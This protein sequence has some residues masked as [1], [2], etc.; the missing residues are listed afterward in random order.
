[1]RRTV[2]LLCLMLGAVAPLAALD[3]YPKTTLAEDG[4]ATWCGYCPDAYAGLDVV[5]SHYNYGEFLS[6]RYYATSGGLGTPET[7]AA[8]AYYGINAFPTVIFNGQ[9][10]VVGGSAFIAT[11]A[12][13][14]PIVQAAYF[15]PAPIRIEISDFSP[16]SGDISATVTMYS[17]T[18]VLAGDQIR[19]L[20][21]E[22]NVVYQSETYSYVTRDI[23]NDT[24]TLSGAGNT[25]VFNKS[26]DV[27]PG[28]NQANLHAVV[29][30]Q[31]AADKEVLQ[32]VSTFPEPSYSVRA[33]VPF[34]RV[35]VG[36]SA[37]GPPSPP[38]TIM[39]VGLA[40][41]FNIELI[42]DF[43]PPGW[44]ASY[45]DDQ[46]GHHTGPWTFALG[47]EESTEFS[48]DV[49]PSS[50]G[51]MKFHLEVS[52]PN[53]TTPLVIPFTYITDDADVLIVDDDGAQTYEN[54][55][56][57]ALD[58]LGISY[59]VWDLSA[60]KLS[61]DVLQAY[62][63]LIWQVGESYPTID[64]VDRAFLTQHLD[65]GGKLFVT[66]QDIGWELNYSSSGNYDPAWY[67]NY[68]HANWVTD[69]TNNYNLDGVAGDPITDGLDL[70]IQ[71][72]DGANNQEYPDA[73]A[74]YDSDAT[75][76]LSYRGSS[77]KGAIRAT[78][79]TSGAKVVY[80]GFGYE[81]IDNPQDRAD[82]LGRALLWLGVN[83][84]LVDGFES[85]DT[86]R[87]SV[88]VP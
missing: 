2:V 69:D 67:H 10:W 72:G 8:L 80:L 17:E 6:A 47:L 3:G 42:V 39:N 73:I 85:G 30:V 49:A 40:D 27:D 11:G 36:P 32:A 26:F 60:G 43:A 63:L 54:Y 52:S 75:T 74:P 15:D 59:G 53:L 5:H 55:Y 84:L 46:G 38:F 16:A 41:T 51:Y 23:I 76:I 65:N 19:F 14:L 35:K 31:R 48:L 4:T 24:I 56:T 33:M 83:E 20:L 78:D 25:A 28:W 29:F 58:S 22:Q 68:L 34:D 45:W 87:W 86:S 71:G 13:Y 70:H 62:R 18:E 79:S 37:P 44:T 9:T 12:A 64:P 57:A 88:T 61:D 21:L 82:M 50:P 66:G 81:A 7:D 77:Y 1:M